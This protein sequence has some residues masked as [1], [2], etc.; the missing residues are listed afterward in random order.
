MRCTRLHYILHAGDPWLRAREKPGCNT[1]LGDYGSA[2]ANIKI[3]ALPAKP[4]ITSKS[5]DFSV[6]GGEGKA[7]TRRPINMQVDVG[8]DSYAAVAREAARVVEC[9]D[10]HVFPFCRFFETRLAMAMC[11]CK[12]SIISF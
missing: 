12:P 6:S 4:D 8:G 1:L 9:L 11:Y 2:E 7:F 10:C 5:N 3:L